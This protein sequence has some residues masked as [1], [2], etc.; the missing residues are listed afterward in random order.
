M[1]CGVVLVWWWVGWL[2][3][4]GGGWCGGDGGEVVVRGR[5]AVVVG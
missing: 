3:G 1:W 2:W 5:V 4:S